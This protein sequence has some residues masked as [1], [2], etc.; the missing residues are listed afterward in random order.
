MNLMA[1]PPPKLVELWRP[2]SYDMYLISY[3]EY[4][5][6]ETVPARRALYIKHLERVIQTCGTG[7]IKHLKTLVTLLID[8]LKDQDEDVVRFGCIRCLKLLLEHGWPR[9]TAHSID[10]LMCFVHVLATSHDSGNKKLYSESR[11]FVLTLKILCKGSLDKHL[12]CLKSFN[13]KGV[14]CMVGYV[15]EK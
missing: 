14:Q 10:L 15:F 4:A 11:E 12:E 6:L 5:G 3:L 8:Y 9:I 7:I 2:N 13:N 1:D